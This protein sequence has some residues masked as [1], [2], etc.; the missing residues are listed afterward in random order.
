MDGRIRI[1]CIAPYENMRSV[2]YAVAKE[3]PQIEITVYVGDLD[4]GLEIALKDFHNDYDAVISR[5]GTAA[6][7]RQKLSLPIVEIPVTPMDI[8]RAMR[9]AGNISILFAGV[10]HASI[11]ERA[12]NIQSLLNIPV[13]LFLVDGEESAMQKLKS[14][15]AHRYTL[16]CD[17]VA[18]RTAQ[19]L[20][21]SAILITSDADNVR[22]AFEETLRIYSNHCRLQEENRFL[23][24]LVWN[25]VHNTVVY[26]PDGELFFSTVSDNSL[27]ILN[28]LQEESKNHDEE[29]NHYLKQI[30]NVLYHIRKHHENLGNQEYTAFY[31][32]ESRVSSPDLRRGIRF[33]SL[34]DAKEK[35]N[36]SFYNVTNM[37][38]WVKEQI[39][40]FNTSDQP[41]MVCGEEGTYKEQ[42]VCYLYSESRWKSHPLIVIDCY[43]LSE[44]SSNYLMDHHNSPLAKND[45]TIFFHDIDVL[46]PMRRYQLVSSLLAMEVCK[47]N[48]VILSCICGRNQRITEE[49]LD[50]TER[51]ECLNLFLPPLRQRMLQIPELATY[52]LNHLNTQLEIQTIGLRNNALNVLQEYDWP[53]NYSQF[54]RVMRGLALACPGKLISKEDVTEILDQEKTVTFMGK[55]VEERDT[56]LDL[57]MTLEDLNKEIVK[58]VLEEEGGNQSATAR[59]LG[60]GRTT[61][62]RL[63]NN[64]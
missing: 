63:L 9:L 2:M 48:R 1:L 52:Y 53:H 40:Q 10:G 5:G 37:I 24:K 23:R 31:F 56:P 38:Q 41:V 50:I 25:Q 55:Y 60:I 36:D 17:M 42:V 59:H 62:W 14:M 47:R 34:A 3:F 45:C 20:Q 8:I 26:T 51:L 35:Y 49:G 61:L 58:R 13:A 43:L 6:M 7:L 15:D 4:V 57:R 28:Y 21:L 30:N 29:Q 44:K 16:L 27:P 54:K 33:L 64:S 39:Q 32:S 46:S 22:S 18:Y 12:K 11:I 19:K